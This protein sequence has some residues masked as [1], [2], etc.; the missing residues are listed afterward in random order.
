MTTT[1]SRPHDPA[2]D[3]DRQGI[4]RPTTTVNHHQD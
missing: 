4:L 2:L 1:Q 3:S